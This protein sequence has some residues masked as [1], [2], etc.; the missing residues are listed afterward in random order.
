MNCV[1]RDPAYRVLK[2][3]LI[4]LTGLAFYSDRD[5][6]LAEVIDGRLSDLGLGDCTSYS[7]FLAE[8]EHGSSELELQI[9][10]LTVG[11]T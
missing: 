8:G 5:T 4:E 11:E 1:L 2:D 10:Q 9:A 3:R 6:L 7:D